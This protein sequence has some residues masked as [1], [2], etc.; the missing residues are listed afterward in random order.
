MSYVLNYM[1][2]YEKGRSHHHFFACDNNLDKRGCAVLIKHGA[3]NHEI[4]DGKIIEKIRSFDV[5][6][7]IPTVIGQIVRVVVIT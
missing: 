6:E 1:G 2:S 5:I 3:F 7:I 4:A